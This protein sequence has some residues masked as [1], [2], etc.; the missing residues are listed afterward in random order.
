MLKYRILKNRKDFMFLKLDRN[1]PKGSRQKRVIVDLQKRKL[2]IGFF[3]YEKYNCTEAC[4]E[5]LAYEIAKV[6]KIK[7]AQIEFA[8]DENGTLGIISYLFSTSENPHTDAKDFFNANDFDRKKFCTLNSI[9]AFLDKYGKNEFGSFIEMM[10]FD[11]LIGETDRHEENWGLLKIARNKYTMS[12]LY[13]TG[14]NLLRQFKDINIAKPYYNKEKNLEDYAKKS[15]TCIYKENGIGRYKH[16]ELIEKLI[17]DYPDITKLK[18]ENI[19][20]LKNWKIRWILNKLPKGI[21]EDMHKEYIYKY[22]IIRK[23]ILLKF[24]EEGEK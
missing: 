11:A 24:L 6:L 2:R 15:Q 21:I 8:K 3:K 4:S 9:K 13:D 5:K 16:F 20:R 22:I 1:N 18:I 19:K 17:R 10:V 14:C 12:P 7:T 23:N